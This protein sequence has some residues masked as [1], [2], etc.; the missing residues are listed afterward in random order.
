[1]RLIGVCC[2]L[3]LFDVYILIPQLL[4]RETDNWG[5][6][7]GRNS[8]TSNHQTTFLWISRCNYHKFCLSIHHLVFTTQAIINN[9]SALTREWLFIKLSA[10]TKWFLHFLFLLYHFFYIC[11]IKFV[12]YIL[13]KDNHISLDKNCQLC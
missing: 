7:Y 6:C 1:M 11:Q 13:Q 4:A 3:L 9:H 2:H 8:I 5:W 10:T 12:E